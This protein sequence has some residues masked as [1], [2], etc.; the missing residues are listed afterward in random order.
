MA[1]HVNI[2]AVSYCGA[3]LQ[4]EMHLFLRCLLIIA[5]ALLALRVRRP[6][7]ATNAVPAEATACRVEWLTRHIH[8]LCDKA[9]AAT[10]ARTAIAAMMKQRTN[11]Q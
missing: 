5:I 8:Q 4:Y 6:S 7:G 1:S 11:S 10:N 9:V 3:K 2:G